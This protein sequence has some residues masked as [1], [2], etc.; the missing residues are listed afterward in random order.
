MTYYHGLAGSIPF[1]E[2]EEVLEESLRTLKLIFKLGGIYCRNK[3]RENGVDIYIEK[4]IG[5]NGD[6]YISIC[7]D[8]PNDD[9]FLGE[10]SG[11]DSSFFRYAKTKIAI[12]FKSAI[13]EDCLF[14]KEP[15]RRL[16]GER[17]VFQYISILNVSRILVGID[18]DLQKKAIDEISKICIP[19]NIPVETFRE[20]LSEERESS[21]SKV[22]SK[23]KNV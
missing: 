5:W 4:D 1:W 10:N 2:S 13:I 6:D 7:V 12:E 21:L 8:N 15:Y 9:E 11:L 20:S 23:R 18:G 14:R 16:P 22:I 17:Q 19:Y 3:L